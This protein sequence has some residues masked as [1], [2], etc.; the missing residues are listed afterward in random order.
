MF[1]NYRRNEEFMLKLMTMLFD[2]CYGDHIQV[3]LLVIAYYQAKNKQKQQDMNCLID[4]VNNVQ[5][6]ML[7]GLAFHTVTKEI[8]NTFKKSIQECYSNFCPITEPIL[9]A[10]QVLHLIQFYKSKM[11][12][13]Y[14][15]MKQVLGHSFRLIVRF[16]K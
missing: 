13:H 6:V 11:N 2:E 9:S 8:D 12:N 4:T 10:S 5:P 16:Q 7:Y 1:F 14:T 15:L 3:Q